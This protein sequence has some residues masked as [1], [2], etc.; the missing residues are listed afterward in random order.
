MF[1]ITCTGFA[2]I[3]LWKEREIGKLK[4]VAASYSGQSVKETVLGRMDEQYMER[5][6]KVEF[7]TSG[8]RV[9]CAADRQRGPGLM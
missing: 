2:Y 7:I 4:E 3:Y 9:A 1:Q 6:R 8:S 5:P